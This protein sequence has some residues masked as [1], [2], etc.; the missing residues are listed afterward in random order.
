MPAGA[1][2]SAEYCYKTLQR[3]LASGEYQ[4]LVRALAWANKAHRKADPD[5]WNVCPHQDWALHCA[6]MSQYY[7]S[8]HAWPAARHCLGNPML[9]VMPDEATPPPLI[10]VGASMQR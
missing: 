2:Q 8:V 7:L 9:A 3:Q 6:T 5:A 10:V 4:P 1:R